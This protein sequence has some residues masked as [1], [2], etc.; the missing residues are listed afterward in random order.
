MLKQRP[1]PAVGGATFTAVLARHT[2][3]GQ[4]GRAFRTSEPLP[5]ES[6]SEKL[7][8]MSCLRMGTDPV[9]GHCFRVYYKRRQ[10]NSNRNRLSSD[11]DTA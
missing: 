9:P 7:L 3:G 2:Q 10:K 8:I 11:S 1:E 4:T 6:K 5:A